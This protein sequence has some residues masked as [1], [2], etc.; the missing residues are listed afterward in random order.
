VLMRRIPAWV[1]HHKPTCRLKP[2]AACALSYFLDA[3]PNFSWSILFFVLIHLLREQ[4]TPHLFFWLQALG[5]DL[6]LR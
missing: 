2:A 3:I 6:L 4:R 5:P 1:I